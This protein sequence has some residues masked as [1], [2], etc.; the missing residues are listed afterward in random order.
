MHIPISLRDIH[1]RSIKLEGLFPVCSGAW[2]L[3][4]RKLIRQ[5]VSTSYIK[6]ETDYC[7]PLR[8]S[9]YV[10][11]RTIQKCLDNSQNSL[12][13]WWRKKHLSYNNGSPRN[14]P[15]TTPCTI[16]IEASRNRCKKHVSFC[17]RLKWQSTTS[18]LHAHAL[19]IPIRL[20]RGAQKSKN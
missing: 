4:V 8:T 16:E 15:G 12:R 19:A 10:I 14:R 18:A 13:W 9:K 1:L 20:M 3:E 11:S 6:T 7:V 17:N 5:E 2:R